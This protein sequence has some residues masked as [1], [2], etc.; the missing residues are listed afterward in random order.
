MPKTKPD[1]SIA[2]SEFQ[3]GLI[4]DQS[5]NYEQAIIH[6]KNSIKERPKFAPAYNN[7]GYLLY[8]VYNQTLN[9]VELFEQAITADPAYS[10]AYNNLAYIYETSEI[11]DPEKARQLYKAEEESYFLAIK[12]APKNPINYYHLACLYKDFFDNK[13]K[14]ITLFRQVIKLDKNFRTALLHTAKL[15][16]TLGKLKKA[17]KYFH[18][19]IIRNPKK[20]HYY[21]DYAH[22]LDKHQSSK[23]AS[24]QFLKTVEKANTKTNKL[25]FREIADYLKIFFH[26]TPNALLYYAKAADANPKNII[27]HKAAADILH[28]D[29]K[30][31]EQAKKYYEFIIKIK[32]KTSEDNFILAQIC[33]TKLKRYITAEK[34]YLKSLI[35]NPK[36][37]IVFYEIIEL[38]LSNLDYL[39]QAK[40]IRKLYSK[41]VIANDFNFLQE[42]E[43]LFNQYLKNKSL[44]QKTTETAFE[45]NA[46]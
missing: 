36:S 24:L 40:K 25:P 41:K 38:Y 31:V 45:P 9:A 34:Y 18:K 42:I 35:K 19:A 44:Q 21:R 39:K 16:A 22:F 4:A 7:L 5:E 29:L 27:A 37:D 20:I 11:K 15:N 33:K 43:Q 17:K 14:A 13:K 12:N 8:T 1:Q 10:P 32:P 30:K 6:Y 23:I 28:Y 26:D 46:V 2:E 3:V